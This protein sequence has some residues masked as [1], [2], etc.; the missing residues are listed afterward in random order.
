MKMRIFSFVPCMLLLG[1]L[2]WGSNGKVSP[3]LKDYHSAD[4]VSVIVQ[5]KVAPAQKHRDRIVAHGG[6]VKQ[7]L[8]TVKGLLVTVPVSRVKELS[9]DPDITYVSPDRPVRRQMNNA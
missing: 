9:D 1:S 6:V 5:F 3:D 4:I 8:H 2:A 7:H